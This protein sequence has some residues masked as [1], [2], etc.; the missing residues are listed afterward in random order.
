MNGARHNI[1]I[2]PLL[3]I[4]S[5][6]NHPIISTISLIFTIYEI[7]SLIINL[8]CINLQNYNIN[9]INSSIDRLRQLQYRQQ[10]K[11]QA[12][13]FQV[14]RTLT[15]LLEQNK[16]IPTREEIVNSINSE[17]ELASLQEYVGNEIAKR[18]TKRR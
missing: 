13:Y 8:E 4:L 15:N 6:I 5:N 11:D 3:I 16:K 17:E 18:R 2:L 12:K 1:I 14:A 10:K 9:R 7:V